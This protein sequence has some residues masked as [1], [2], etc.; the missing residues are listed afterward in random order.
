[1]ERHFDAELKELNN[2]I[3][4]MGVFAQEAIFN[5]VEALKNRDKQLAKRVID[6]DAAVD[7]LE[8]AVDEKCV[9]LIARYQPMAKSDVQ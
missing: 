5:S 7:K 8:L 4:Q 9:D 6:N 1:M 2:D 3:L